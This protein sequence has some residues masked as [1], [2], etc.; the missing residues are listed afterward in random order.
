MANYQ[1]PLTASMRNQCENRIDILPK[2]A[3]Y[4]F[5][6][7]HNG[8]RQ[9]TSRTYKTCNCCGYQTF[10]LRKRNCPNC[11]V[12]AIWTKATETKEEAD[13]RATTNAR[14]EALLRELVSC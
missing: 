12:P 14:H 2:I 13:A 5:E 8:D 7:T 6:Q 11:G 9:M 10:W 1:K 3:E 4:V